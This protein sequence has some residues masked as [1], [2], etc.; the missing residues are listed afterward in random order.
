M[1][2]VEQKAFLFCLDMYE[3]FINKAKIRAVKLESYFKFLKPEF[4][5]VLV[6]C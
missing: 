6:N 3:S 1:L 4:Q 2:D 5:R